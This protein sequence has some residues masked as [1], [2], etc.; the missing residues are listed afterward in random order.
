MGDEGYE[1][2]SGLDHSFLHFESQTAYMHVALTAIFD[3]GSLVKSDG[4]VDFERI[5]LHF[6][7]RLHLLPR[8]RQ[9]LGFVPVTNDPVWVDDDE[10]SLQFHLRHAHLP[11]PGTDEQLRTLCAHILER[12]LDRRKPLWEAWFIEGLPDRRFAM[13]CKVHHC[14]VDGIAGI[15]LLAALLAPAPSTRMAPAEPWEPRPLPGTR[16]LLQSEARRRADA[17]FE[18][19]RGL[20]A[21][22]ARGA[23]KELVGRAA[24]LW[25]LVRSSVRQTADVPF[26]RTIG[27]NRRIA[28]SSFE[29]DRLKAVKQVLGGTLNDVVLAVVAGAVRRFLRLRQARAEGGAFRVLVPVSTRTGSERGQTGNRVSAWLVTLPIDEADPLLRYERVCA[30]TAAL[31]DGDEAR[32]VEI[33]TGTADWV[34][35]LGLDLAVRLIHRSRLFNLLVTNVPGP[36]VPF[37]LLDARMVAAYPHVPLFEG[38]GLAIALV[39]YAGRLSCCLVGD[40]DQ[41]PDLDRFADLVEESFLELQRS[42]GLE[43]STVTAGRQ[44][45][46]RRRVRTFA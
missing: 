12:P 3:A 13:L 24:T 22:L 29:L 11:K 43:V 30:T 44:V 34:T 27:P 2:L 39:S 20:P 15:D 36:P 38:Q 18:L 14:M 25:G 42:A 33:L 4:G 1:R 37:F 8:Y 19:L 7:S 40:W 5:R 9:R 28:W 45:R 31:R 10:F 23:P 32:S 35:S 16:E 26:N 17:S 41:V 46:A 21:W 6:A